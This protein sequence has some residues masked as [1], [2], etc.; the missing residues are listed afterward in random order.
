M[1]ACQLIHISIDRDWNDDGERAYLVTPLYRRHGK[2][3]TVPD[4]RG[5]P[6]KA[7]AIAEA[8]RIAGGKLE[9]A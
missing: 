8:E 3:M 6:T 9:N 7:E 2:L 1:T 5:W 4:S